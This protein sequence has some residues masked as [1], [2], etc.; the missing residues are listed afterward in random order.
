MKKMLSWLLK[1]LLTIVFLI[2]VLFSVLAIFKIPV[3]L[4]FAIGP[5]EAL[6]TKALDRP[7]K[8]NDSVVVST[9][10]SPNF[11]VKGLQIKNPEGFEQEDFLS[12]DLANLQI[13]L[14][15]LLKGKLHLTL[16][17]VKGLDIILE[18]NKSD[19][20]EARVEQPAEVTP[21]PQQDKQ[22]TALSSDTLVIENLDLQEIQVDF[23]KPGKDEQIRFDL[24][25]CQGGME[26]GEPLVLSILGMIQ[27]FD[28]SVN[29]SIGSLEELLV[30]NR[31]WAEIRAQIAGTRFS[32]SGSVDLRTSTKSMDLKTSV[33]GSSLATLS[34]LLE[35][36]LPPFTDYQV[37]TAL[38]LQPGKAELQ[39]LFV[40]TGTSRLEGSMTVI[41]EKENLVVGILLQSDTFFI[42]T[43]Q[44]RLC[45]EG[46]VDFKPE[47][48]DP[49]AKPKAKRAE[50]FSLGTPLELHGSFSDIHV[51]L[52]DGGAIGT[53]IKFLTSPITVPLQRTFA[54]EIPEN[55]SDVC[56]MPL[57]SVQREELQVP[58]CSKN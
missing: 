35:L 26:V 48:I 29:V 8:I 39:K 44:M 10:L 55:G 13:N 15:P 16:F 5:I 33:R 11:I 6:V 12:M 36:D 27:D 14:V 2:V 23:H 25:S 20:R 24:S 9:S 50:F 57:G 56:E 19:D 31:S 40:Q 28:Y 3:D 49:A 4:S 45:A 37:E 34:D 21:E 58:L 38:H 7:V 42:D 43:S 41:E 47:R 18:E 51:G 17:Q 22:K 46:E 54:K 32:F 53:G 1:S 52:G 30:E